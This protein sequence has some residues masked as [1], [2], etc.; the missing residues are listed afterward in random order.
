MYTATG[1]TVAVGARRLLDDVEL[2]LAPNRIT[3]LIG[4]NG[5][6]KSTL[7][8]VIAGELRPVK[9]SIRLHE[10][11]IESYRPAELA[12]FRSVLPQSTALAFAFSAE[13]V[14]RLGLSWAISAKA[15]DELV[16]RAL[17]TVGMAA[18]AKRSCL[19]LSG[20]ERQRVHLARVLVQLWS[21]PDDG[22][23]RF[24]MLD[25]PVTGL[26]LSHQLLVIRLARAHA[27]AG[28]GVLAVMHDLNLAAMLGDEIVAL[29]RGRIVARG[30][31]SAVITDRL[32]REVYDVGLRVG[33]PTP[34][35]FVLPQTEELSS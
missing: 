20:G 1:V 13:E 27:A 22:L 7:L 29:D 23:A 21:Q 3:V 28:G 11:P 16:A 31:P 17:T 15:G 18:A 5:A 33:A 25:E 4:P 12:R 9:G 24:L 6:G 26:D 10:R 32:L 35:V 8:K 2:D 14:V 34:G 19:S 30:T